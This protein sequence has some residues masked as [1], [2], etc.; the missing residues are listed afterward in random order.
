MFITIDVHEI[1]SCFYN[2]R[3]HLQV[4]LLLLFSESM[5]LQLG[6]KVSTEFVRNPLGALF[7]KGSSINDATLTGECAGV[8]YF[9]TT[10]SKPL[11]LNV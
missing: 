1:L 10:V 5:N 6:S 4:T 3:S 7:R 2:P 9:V 8:K 11:Y